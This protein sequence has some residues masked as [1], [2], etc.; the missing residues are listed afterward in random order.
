MAAKVDRV[1]FTQLSLVYL[2][3]PRLDLLV[4]SSLQA[5]EEGATAATFATRETSATA[6]LVLMKVTVHRAQ[7]T[8][9]GQG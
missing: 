8:P 2:T 5:R 3:F 1:C 7:S 6:G 4:L 9:G